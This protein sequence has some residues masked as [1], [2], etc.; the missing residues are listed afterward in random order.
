MAGLF[1]VSELEC[2]DPQCKKMIESYAKDLKLSSLEGIR[3][4]ELICRTYPLLYL[5]KG[6]AGTS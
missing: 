2:E 6:Y 4:L 5:S 1:Y 3:K